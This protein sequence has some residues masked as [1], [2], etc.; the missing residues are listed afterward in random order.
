MKMEVEVQYREEIIAEPNRLAQTMRVIP[1]FKGLKF[2]KQD[3]D[4]C[5]DEIVAALGKR[6][7]GKLQTALRMGVK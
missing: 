4:K 7:L 6:K 3:I 2:T 1:T 5:S